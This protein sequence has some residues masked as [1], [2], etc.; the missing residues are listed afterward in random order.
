MTIQRKTGFCLGNSY[1]QT[2]HVS[3]AASICIAQDGHSFFFISM[4]GYVLQENEI[5]WQHIDLNGIIS[6][7]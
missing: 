4:A 1:W 5:Y 2:G 3:A 6:S 7:C